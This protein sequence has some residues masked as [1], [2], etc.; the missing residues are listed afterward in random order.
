MPKGQLY[1]KSST[2]KE[3]VD[4]WERY[5]LG[6]ENGA[7]DALMAPAPCKK[8][9]SNSNALTDGIACLKASI[10]KKDSKSLSLDIH[11]CGGTRSEYMKRYSLFCNEILDAGYFLLKTAYQEDT[12][13]HLLYQD[14]QPFQQ[15]NLK[16]AK[17]TLSLIE[18]HPEIH[19]EL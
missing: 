15:Y 3:W 6:L 14:C 13:F 17:F 4:A 9:T 19:T 1:L 5:S 12:V 18:P 7:L 16:M 10:G 11:I 2:T 8:P